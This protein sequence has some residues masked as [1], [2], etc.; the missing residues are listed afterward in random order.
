MIFKVPRAI[1]GNYCEI[2]APGSG[3]KYDSIRVEYV[4][5]LESSV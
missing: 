4:S 3:R 2:H 1:K 5:T